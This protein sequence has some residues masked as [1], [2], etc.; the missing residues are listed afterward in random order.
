MK[1]RIM[2]SNGSGGESW[3]GVLKSPMELLPVDS[4]SV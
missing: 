2:E 1:T 4:T 3:D